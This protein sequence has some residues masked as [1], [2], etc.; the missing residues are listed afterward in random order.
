MLARCLDV[1]L[2]VSPVDVACAQGRYR[3]AGGPVPVLDGFLV[4]VVLVGLMVDDR[5]D[6]DEAE[7]S[8]Q[9]PQGRRLV[10]VEFG[11]RPAG[12]APRWL[13]AS[14]PKV[15]VDPAA[16]ELELVDLAFA[17]VLAAGLEREQFGISRELLQLGQQFSHRHAVRVAR[18]AQ[19]GM[20]V[21]LEVA[22]P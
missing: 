10:G 11:H 15:Q 13:V 12:L 14:G 4:V 19:L 2:A 9:A 5:Q 8:S 7:S 16:L 1:E 6:L 17:V 3:R 18:R 22:L 21:K 20:R